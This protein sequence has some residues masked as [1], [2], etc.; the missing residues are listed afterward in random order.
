MKLKIK[1]GEIRMGV[2]MP[3]QPRGFVLRLFMHN[4]SSCLFNMHLYK[5]TA[6]P[7]TGV[8]KFQGGTDDSSAVLKFSQGIPTIFI[9][10]KTSCYPYYYS[11]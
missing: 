6:D 7:N 4:E 8:I 10:L 1:Y 11:Q 9:P 3:E 5:E 2:K